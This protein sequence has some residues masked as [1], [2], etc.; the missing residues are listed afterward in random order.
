M[1]DLSGI[2]VG[3]LTSIARRACVYALR[4]V[5]VNRPYLTRIRERANRRLQRRGS[6]TQSSPKPTPAPS[7]LILLPGGEDGRGG[8]F[9]PWEKARMRALKKKF[10]HAIRL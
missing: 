7:S 4:A 8:S 3:H 1:K 2:Q 6:L 9:S 10:M 5:Q